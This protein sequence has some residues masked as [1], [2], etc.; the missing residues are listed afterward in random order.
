MVAI[1]VSHFCEKTSLFLNELILS[2]LF[3]G[4]VSV[5]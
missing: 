5:K 2:V 1:L 4:M 3:L